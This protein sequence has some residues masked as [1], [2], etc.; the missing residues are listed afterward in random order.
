MGN[1]W[2]CKL[3]S[4]SFWI[5]LCFILFFY[6]L[7]YK[8]KI[9]TNQI[10]FSYFTYKYCIYTL[11]CFLSLLCVIGTANVESR[12]AA[13]LLGYKQ[14]FY[15]VFVIQV[16]TRLILM[17]SWNIV[18]QVGTRGV[19]NDGHEEMY[20]IFPSA[21]HSRR[22]ESNPECWFAAACYYNHCTLSFYMLC[23]KLQCSAA[24]CN[25]IPWVN[26]Q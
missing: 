12:V 22:H 5:T 3:I 2:R 14:S 13:M 25:D 8:N 18:W 24:V 6:F 4:F 26:A 15:I 23:S 7:F 10:Y 17:C 19:V 9:K 21:H 20:G 1:M 16:L 11:W